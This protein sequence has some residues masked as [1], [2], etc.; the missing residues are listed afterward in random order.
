MDKLTFCQ[1]GDNQ[2][3]ANYYP[4]MFSEL[5]YFLELNAKIKISLIF[6]LDIYADF[7]FLNDDAIVGLLFLLSA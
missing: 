6:I 2:K 5:F 3:N 7:Y 4:I 1:S